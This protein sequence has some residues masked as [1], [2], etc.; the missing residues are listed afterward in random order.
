MERKVI[1]SVNDL[2]VYVLAYS[3]ALDVFGLSK[4]FPKEESYSLTDQIRR[5]SRSI[6]ANISEGF[7]KKQ[8]ENVFKQHLITAMGSVEETKTWID[9]AKDFSYINNEQSAKLKRDY[10]KIGAMLYRLI[11]NWHTI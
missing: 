11:Q 9:F 10:T 7:A 5:S 6:P 4:R 3:L 2:E 8:Y 1:K